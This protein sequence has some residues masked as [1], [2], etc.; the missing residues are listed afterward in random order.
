MMIFPS[1]YKWFMVLSRPITGSTEGCW[2]YH[3]DLTKMETK[4]WIVLGNRKRQFKY[5]GYIR[6]NEG[7][8]NLSPAGHIK[9]MGDRKKSMDLTSLCGWL[10]EQEVK[11]KRQFTQHNKDNKVVKSLYRPRLEG[12]WHFS[13]MCQVAFWNKWKHKHNW[14]GN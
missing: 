14:N 11:Q 9:I 7:L 1:S 6:I 5:L 12:T 3:R 8:E 10:A 2:E 13:S 4:R